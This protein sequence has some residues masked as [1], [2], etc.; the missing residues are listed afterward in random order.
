MPFTPGR[1]ALGQVHF[2]RARHLL[3]G[4]WLHTAHGPGSAPVLRRSA[5]IA[6]SAPAMLMAGGGP[7]TQGAI[8]NTS[9]N[10]TINRRSHGS[11]STLGSRNSRPVRK[12]VCFSWL[13]EECG[14]DI[15]RASRA[16]IQH[17]WG[18]KGPRGTE[19]TN[20]RGR[21]RLWC[22]TVPGTPPKPVGSPRRLAQGG[23][24]ICLPLSPEGSPSLFLADR[25]GAGLVRPY[26]AFC[27]KQLLVNR[28]Q[29]RAE[30]RRQAR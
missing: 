19:T 3:P 13:I 10:A 9:G 16:V 21:H 22:P 26:Q 27:Q 23:L 28:A 18:P 4:A 25:S 5:G 14:S 24:L 8:H 7:A 29:V 12:P 11:R 15:E 2:P 6:P 1:P 17:D 20:L 30:R